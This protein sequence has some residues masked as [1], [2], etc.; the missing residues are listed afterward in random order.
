VDLAGNIP[1]DVDAVSAASTSLITRTRYPP[2]CSQLFAPNGN[3][4]RGDGLVQKQGIP[5]RLTTPVAGVA[6]D[7]CALKSGAPML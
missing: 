6:E 7:Q 4:L 3:T 5:N 1:P 2:R